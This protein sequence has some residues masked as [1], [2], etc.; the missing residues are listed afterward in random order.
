MCYGR[1]ASNDVSA[2]MSKYIVDL[3]CLEAGAQCFPL[4]FY[5]K[6]EAPKP[7]MQGS[8]LGVNNTPEQS[9]QAYTRRD[10]ITDEGLK[11]FT[12]AYPNEKITKEWLLPL[13]LFV[14]LGYY[15]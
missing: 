13:L 1:G 8:L 12:T 15:S 3:N 2:L 4:Y 9:A 6:A 5:D 7:N 11:H 14:L 10:A